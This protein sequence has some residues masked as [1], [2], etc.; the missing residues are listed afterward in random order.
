MRER[1]V[2]VARVRVVEK[3][4][5]ADVVKKVEEDCSMARDHERL[6]VKSR[7]LPVQSHRTTNEMCFIKVGF[8]NHCHGYQ[9]KNRNGTYLENMCC[10]G[11]CSEVLGITRFNCRIVSGGVVDW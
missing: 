9:L 1:K 5:Y 3:V 2:E 10:G 8:F 6:P 4:S 11:S 7:I